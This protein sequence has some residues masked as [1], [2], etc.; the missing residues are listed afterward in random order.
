M[1]VTTFLDFRRTFKTV[2]RGL[3]VAKLTNMDLKTTVLER[4]LLFLMSCFGKF[5]PKR[6]FLD[7]LLFLK[8]Y[9]L[10]Q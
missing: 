6:L 3:L 9:N 5:E 7:I 8:K 1:T 10:I 2:N 4:C